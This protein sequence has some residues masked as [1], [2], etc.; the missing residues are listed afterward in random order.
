MRFQDGAN[1]MKTKFKQ[2]LDLVCIN[3]G[4]S[5]HVDYLIFIFRNLC[6]HIW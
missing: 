1:N 4:T 5:N 6:F 3:Y 2:S